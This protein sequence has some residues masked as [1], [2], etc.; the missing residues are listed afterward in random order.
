MSYKTVLA[1]VD[2]ASDLKKSLAGA[3]EV[4]RWQKAHLAVLLVS[5]SESLPF[6]GYGGAGYTEIWL[7]EGEARAAALKEM[8]DAA[9]AYLSGEDLSFDV[10]AHQAIATRQDNLVARHAIYSDL[11]VIY[12]AEKDDLSTVESQ[13]IDG[14]LFDSG[15]PLLF[16]PDGASSGLPGK[17]V[18]IAWN[19]RAEAAE[20]VK[21]AVPILKDAEQVTLLVVDPVTG[22]DDH[23]EEPGADMA[24]VLARHMIKVSV[25]PVV[26]EGKD[27]SQVIQSEAE[28]TGADLIV[29]G[30]YGHSRVRQN[31]LGGTTRHMLE[32]CSIPLFLAH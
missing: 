23:G 4:A 2:I 22:P 32:N 31:I 21:D 14:A 5:E 17:N 18:L 8:A 24:L 16:V 29:M 26:S 28:Q 3:V 7:K 25:R 20:A 30:A 12:R 19:S 11:T 15:R 1:V 6:Y 9:D 27:I 10:R 13:A